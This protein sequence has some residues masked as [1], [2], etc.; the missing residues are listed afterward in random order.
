MSIFSLIDP[1]F[2]GTPT[3]TDLPTALDNFRQFAFESFSQ[4][5]TAAHESPPVDQSNPPSPSDKQA[6][7]AW[8]AR[9]AKAKADMMSALQQL[10]QSDIM[11][12]ESKGRAAYQKLA[13]LIVSTNTALGDIMKVTSAQTADD[14]RA[15]ADLLSAHAALLQA[16]ANI[17]PVATWPGAKSSGG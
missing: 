11:L 15:Y 14:L 5:L 12:S 10:A 8:D 16:L 1:L 9:V 17:A 2:V 13:D 4:A 6:R 3:V 7:A